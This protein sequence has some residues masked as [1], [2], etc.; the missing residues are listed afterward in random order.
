MNGYGKLRHAA[1]LSARQHKYQAS[2]AAPE[3]PIDGWR[4]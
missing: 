2:N 4:V 1:H 3:D